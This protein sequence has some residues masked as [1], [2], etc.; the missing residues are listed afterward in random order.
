MT[1]THGIHHRS[2]IAYGDD[3]GLDQFATSIA[4]L[5]GDM[6]APMAALEKALT[7]FVENLNATYGVDAYSEDRLLREKA[8][9][10]GYDDLIE[11]RSKLEWL[12]GERMIE[13]H[14]SRL[15]A[16]ERIRS[17]TAA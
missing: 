3:V 16:A 9:S 4:A 15:S 8:S 6:T 12:I 11:F 10:L 5:A 14:V 2:T 13:L 1:L 7:D 17:K